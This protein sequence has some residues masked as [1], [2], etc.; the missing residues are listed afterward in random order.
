MGITYLQQLLIESLE[1]YKFLKIAEAN[2]TFA[3]VQSIIEL[4]RRHFFTDVKEFEL[5]RLSAQGMHKVIAR[6]LFN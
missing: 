1:K 4:L 3:D 2:S 6:N 5:E